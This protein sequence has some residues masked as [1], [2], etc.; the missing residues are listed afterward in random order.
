MIWIHCNSFF[1]YWIVQSAHM[2]PRTTTKKHTH[3]WKITTEIEFSILPLLLWMVALVSIGGFYAPACQFHSTFY[4]LTISVAKTNDLQHVSRLWLTL[5]CKYT[6]THYSPLHVLF[7]QKAHTFFSA[8]SLSPP[9]C[10]SCSN[11]MIAFLFRLFILSFWKAEEKLREKKQQIYTFYETWHRNGH[12]R[13]NGE[14]NTN[15]RD[16]SIWNKS[17]HA[18]QN[19]PWTVR[20]FNFEKTWNVFDATTKRCVFFFFVSCVFFIVASFV[21]VCVSCSHLQIFQQ[22]AH[23]IT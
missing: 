8:L 15:I 11:P 9:Q 16:F 22:N 18:L 14:P 10:W 21:C 4:V 5:K 23:L 13:I 19:K 6:L 1:C 17:S 3:T 20:T 12:E 2:N 7:G